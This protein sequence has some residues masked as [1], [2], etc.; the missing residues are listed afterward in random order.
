MDIDDN[1]YNIYLELNDTT[2]AMLLHRENN[3]KVDYSDHDVIMKL[4]AETGWI[5]IKA[6][7]KSFIHIQASGLYINDYN[8]CEVVEFSFKKFDYPTLILQV[9][10]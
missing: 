9:N 7:S 8:D 10:D 3:I 4:S 1:E 2:I 6:G 5:I